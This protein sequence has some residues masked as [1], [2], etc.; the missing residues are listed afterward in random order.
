MTSPPEKAE[1]GGNNIPPHPKVASTTLDTNINS[2]K[3]SPGNGETMGCRKYAM[4][5]HQAQVNGGGA[6]VPWGRF[7]RNG[8]II[9]LEEMGEVFMYYIRDP[10]RPTWVEPLFGIE[11]PNKS[12]ES[13]G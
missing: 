7:E 2:E 13:P 10:D 12:R 8:G 9:V 3:N 5:T 4:I 1:I 6:V 11:K